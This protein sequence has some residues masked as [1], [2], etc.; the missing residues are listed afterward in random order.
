MR[1]AR[2]AILAIRIEEALPKERILE[3]YLNEIFL[4]YQAYGVAAAAQAYFNKGLDELT[5]GEAAFLGALP[6]APN[7]YNPLRYPEAATRPPRLGAGPHGGGRRHHRRRRPRRQGASR[8]VPRLLRRPEVV[9]VGQY[10]TEDVRRE[11]ISRFGPEQTA[12]GGLVVRTSLEPTLQGTAEKI[13]A[14]PPHGLRP[15]PRRLARAGRPHLRPQR[16]MD[17]AAGGGAAPR[18]PAAGMEAGGGAGNEGTEAKLGWVERP[19][20]R[21]PSQ[22]RMGTLGMDG[23]AWR[24][25]QAGRRAATAARSAASATWWR[26]ATWCRQWSPRA[27][28]DRADAA[29]GARS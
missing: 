5:V 12:G 3:L 28:G 20:P 10:F 16:R 7:N 9:Q 2:E 14:R 15:P 17:A 4:G 25:R 22:P 24:R 1:K 23:V 11:L 13:A 19:D 27:G 21:V 29:A 8:I 6:K 26:W 18:R